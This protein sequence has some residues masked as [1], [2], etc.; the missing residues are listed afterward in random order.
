MKNNYRSLLKNKIYLITGSTGYL[1]NYL[2]K[3]L[4]N[5]TSKLILVD[6][7]NIKLKKQKQNFY[8]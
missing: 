2:S 8:N 4:A 6:K 5:N 1:G 7:D 3:E